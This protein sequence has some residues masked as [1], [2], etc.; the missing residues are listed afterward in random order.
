MKPMISEFSYGYTLTEELAS[1]ILGPIVGAPIFPS[2]Y[3]EGQPGGGYDLE[4]PREGA[5][6]FLQ[7]KLSHYLKRSNANEW[8][9]FSSAYYRMHLRPPLYSD[10]HELLIELEQSG[11]EVYYV[12]PMFHRA[13]ELNDAYTTRNVFNRSVFF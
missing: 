10:Q 11:N 13:E 12:A 1:G 9:Y 8:N 7:F 5:P 6:L 4:L 3:Q 2:L